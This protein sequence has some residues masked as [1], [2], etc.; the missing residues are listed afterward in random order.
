VAAEYSACPSCLADDFG[1]I[2]ARRGALI[3]MAQIGD[4]N[5]TKRSFEATGVDP[6]SWTLAPRTSS[7]WGHFQRFFGR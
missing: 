7:I 4:I 1:P 3:V 5:V 2:G 6:L